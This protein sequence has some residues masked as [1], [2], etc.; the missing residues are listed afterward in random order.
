MR[1]HFETHK[2]QKYGRG[3]RHTKNDCAD[4]CQH[5]TTVLHEMGWMLGE[6]VLLYLMIL[7]LPTLV[8]KYDKISEK[9]QS[10]LLILGEIR[11]EC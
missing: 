10:E 6:T 5:Q 7:L 4:E 1:P 3:F 9:P 11:T 8:W 2:E